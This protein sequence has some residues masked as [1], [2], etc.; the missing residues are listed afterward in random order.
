MMIDYQA[1]LL[2]RLD[3]YISS[4][5]SPMSYISYFFII[6][7]LKICSLFWKLSLQKVGIHYLPFNSFVNSNQIFWWKDF[8]LHQDSK[9]L[10]AL[11]PYLLEGTIQKCN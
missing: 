6:P 5:K 4:R 10:K 2:S 1:D 8:K 3:V 9:T 7:Q 11:S